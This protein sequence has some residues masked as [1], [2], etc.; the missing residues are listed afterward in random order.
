MG[1]AIPPPPPAPTPSQGPAH[2]PF[3]K[4]TWVWVAVAIVALLALVGSQ[5]DQGTDED[6]A[7]AS[8]SPDVTAQPTSRT[9]AFDGPGNGLI[10]GLQMD[11]EI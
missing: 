10:V 11:A 8:S 6:R 2:R 5:I 4:K 7:A 9:A 3:W 1:Q